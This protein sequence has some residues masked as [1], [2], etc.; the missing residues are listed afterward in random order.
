MKI[1]V[2]ERPMKMVCYWMSAEEGQDEKLMTS[3]KPQFKEWKL[4][5]YQPVV[6]VSGKGSLED[7]MYMLMKRNHDRLIKM[8]AENGISVTDTAV[9]M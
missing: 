9:Q 8:Q 3:L 2:T 5:K 4:K 6:Y 7:G 1:E